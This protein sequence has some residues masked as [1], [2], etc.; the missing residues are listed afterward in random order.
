MNYLPPLLENMITVLLSDQ[1]SLERQS[2]TPGT[3]MQMLFDECY[4]DKDIRRYVC[5][6]KT[7]LGT[8]SYVVS[9]DTEIQDNDSITI[10]STR[11]I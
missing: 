11:R 10:I 1:G 3:T 5:R 2:Y 6:I 9:P 8:A 7:K 4:P